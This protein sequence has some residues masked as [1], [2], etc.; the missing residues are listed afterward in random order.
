MVVIPLGNFLMGETFIGQWQSDKRETSMGVTIEKPFAAGRFA[1]AREEF[2]F[3]ASATN[4]HMSGGCNALIG[5]NTVRQREY[6]W[7]SPGFAQDDRHPVV[8][9]DWH[10]A[11]DYAA[12]LSTS[13]AKHTA[14]YRMPNVNTSPATCPFGGGE[15]ST[16]VANYN[17]ASIGTE[18]KSA[19]RKATMPVD[20]F[21]PKYWG[22]FNVHGNVWDWT[23]SLLAQ[24]I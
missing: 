22:L 3:F 2:A 7:Q 16:R 11:K 23:V 6:S 1:V 10:D 24:F 5:V 20:A 19:W 8:C 21:A 14:F 15:L 18:P 12:W 4:R 13:T 17:G 9:V